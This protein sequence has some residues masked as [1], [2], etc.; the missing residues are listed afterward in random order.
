MIFSRGETVKS[1]Y[2]SGVILENGVIRT[3]EPSLPLGRDWNLAIARQS[4]EMRRALQCAVPTPEPPR[5]SQMLVMT[6]CDKLK[7]P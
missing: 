4:P 3:M 5:G 2:A 6:V 1:A 7:S